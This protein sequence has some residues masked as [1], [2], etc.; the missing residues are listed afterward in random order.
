MEKLVSIEDVRKTPIGNKILS[1]ITLKNS[2]QFKYHNYMA[3]VILQEK[4]KP[5]DEQKFGP[6][7]DLLPDNFDEFPVSLN[8]TKDGGL[9]LLENTQLLL[10]LNNRRQIYQQDYDK[11]CKAVPEFAKYNLT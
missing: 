9:D 11:I 8:N 1:N 10:A 4:E 3:A 2:L 6:Y 7:I 5:K